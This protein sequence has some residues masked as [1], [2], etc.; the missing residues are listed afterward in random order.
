MAGAIIEN[1]STKKLVIAGVILLLFQVFSFL[2]GGL[3][4]KFCFLRLLRCRILC[5]PCYSIMSDC[6]DLIR[7]VL[8]WEKLERHQRWRVSIYA[9]ILAAT[10]KFWPSYTAVH[11][12][13]SE[14]KKTIFISWRLIRGEKLRR[15]EI[16]KFSFAP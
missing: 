16:L 6:Y 14:V 10:E 8:Y 9:H 2:V 4:G 5:Y 12:F 7:F 15:S 1:M 3:I 13:S 11:F